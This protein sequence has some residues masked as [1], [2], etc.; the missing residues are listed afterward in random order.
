MGDVAIFNIDALVPY[1]LGSS[2]VAN[3]LS[4]SEPLNICTIEY[5]IINITEIKMQSGRISNIN[6]S[7]HP[8]SSFLITLTVGGI[9][10][11]K[12]GIQL[13]RNRTVGNSYDRATL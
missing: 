4:K 6:D 2:L 13:G 7:N 10:K 9:N 12:G 1:C 3:T 11:T 5:S 8:N